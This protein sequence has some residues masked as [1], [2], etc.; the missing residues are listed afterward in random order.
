MN[1]LSH[2]I[3]SVESQ[4]SATPESAT[5]VKEEE[6][7]EPT[8]TTAAVTSVSTDPAPETSTLTINDVPIG[9]RII[10]SLTCVP[11][12]GRKGNLFINVRIE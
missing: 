2:L 7:E 6:E 9:T 12:P 4:P 5:P 11:V 1:H 8:N 3:V 10:G